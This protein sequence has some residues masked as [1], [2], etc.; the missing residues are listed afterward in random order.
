[1]TA[2]AIGRP[3]AESAAEPRHADFWFREVLPEA[4]WRTLPREIRCRF[5][6]PL[7][8]DDVALYVG[9]VVETRMS[10][11]GRML[12]Q[13]ARL[14]GSPLPLEPAGTGPAI[15]SVVEDHAAAGQVW[16]RSYA[17]KGRFPQVISSIKRFAGP[18]GLE[19]VVGGGIA[20][21]LRVC[22]EDGALVFRAEDYCLAFRGRRL[23]IPRW[24]APGR[25]TIRHAQEAGGR[26][27]FTLDVDH[28]RLGR[29]LH[30]VAHFEDIERA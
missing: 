19:E 2:I 14:I 23:P 5:G 18:T 17:R 12:A 7:R 13:L 25:M 8:D 3:R 28:P 20:M 10:P 27:S 29:I 16:T 22:V 24:L 1:M 26:F 6:R 4:E 30:Q 11:S 21:A 15:V 9:R